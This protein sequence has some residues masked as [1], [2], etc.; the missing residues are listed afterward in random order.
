MAILS[1]LVVYSI[2]KNEHDSKFVIF[3]ILLLFF[4]IRNIYY[5]STRNV[6][7]FG[8]AY[9]DYAVEKIFLQQGDI[10]AV[11]AVVRPTEAGGFSQLSWYS[12]WPAL[13]VF[14][15]IFSFT[16]GIDLLYLNWILPNVLALVSFGFLYLFFEKLLIRLNLRKDVTLIALLL[17]AIYPEAIFW[18]M[19]YVRQSLALAMLMPIIYFLYV[20][21]FERFDK[22]YLV[23]LL[24]LIPTLVLSHHVTALTITLFLFV[25]FIINVFAKRLG[26]WEQ[27]DSFVSPIRT[28]LFLVVGFLTA[29]FLIFW[30][31]TQGE[32]IF[33]TILSRLFL[34]FKDLGLERIVTQA[35]ISYPS[36][37]TPQWVS[38]VL[39]FR[40]LMLYGMAMFG[41]L[42][43]WRSKSVVQEKFFIIYSVFGFG[44]ILVINVIFRIEPVRIILFMAPFLTFLSAL[45][46]SKIKN[47]S[48]S[49]S[50]IG[51]FIVLTAIVFSSFLG[52]WAHSFAPVHLYDSSINPVDIGEVTP[53]FIRLKSFFEE[54]IN[55]S[56]YQFV[57][58]DVISR[59]V[60]LLEPADFDKIKPLPME[61]EEFYKLNQKGTLVCAFND[62]NLYLYFGNIWS[63]I[64]AS[65]IET[66]RFELKQFLNDNYN[67]IYRDDAISIWSYPDTL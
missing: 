24:V 55:I 9:W 27:L 49:F 63:P 29:I 50:K 20:L 54:N 66:L 11:E 38:P 33:P 22:R 39:G 30:W 18:Q 10:T 48:R 15:V 57:R 56:K 59:L 23:I 40:D 58:A 17:Y 19:Q 14:G 60:F 12:G 47:I 4:L 31:S 2:I 8:D 46:Y 44:F 51:V 37:L 5:L 34:L 36:V 21:N 62:L 64:Q 41:L 26:R 25:F 35:T 7:P 32:L 6:I 61:L 16:T 42:I 3:Q 53:D 28:K 67:L 43:L 13:H 45:F 65:E 52:L 1:V